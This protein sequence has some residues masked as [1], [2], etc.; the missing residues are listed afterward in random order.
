[1]QVKSCCCGL[2]CYPSEA[3]SDSKC[4]RR[5]Q[6]SGCVKVSVAGC[7]DKY[8]DVLLLCSGAIFQYFRGLLSI[9]HFSLLDLLL[10]IFK[11]LSVLF[12][13]PYVSPSSFIFLFCPGVLLSTNIITN[14][15]QPLTKYHGRY[16]KLPV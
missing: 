5:I 10:P 6:D 12:F 3:P 2:L 11:S 14:P 13:P 9:H 4:V 7:C 15:C 16:T 1:M 8:Y